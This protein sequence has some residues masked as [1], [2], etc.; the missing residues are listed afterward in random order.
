MFELVTRQ[1]C[2][3]FSCGSDPGPGVVTETGQDVVDTA[4]VFAG[5]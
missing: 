3:L 4:G 1:V 2:E 5:D